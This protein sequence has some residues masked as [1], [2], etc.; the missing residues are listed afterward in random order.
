M[1]QSRQPV[2]FHEKPVSQSN[3]MSLEFWEG[4]VVVAFETLYLRAQM[5]FEVVL[6]CKVRVF[7][8]T[9]MLG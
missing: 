7:Y 3:E 2:I 9:K 1:S 6:W 5:E 4:F 8:L